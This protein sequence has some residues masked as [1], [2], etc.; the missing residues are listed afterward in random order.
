MP[1]LVRESVILGFKFCPVCSLCYFKLHLAFHTPGPQMFL[2]RAT[3]GFFEQTLHGWLETTFFMTG[4]D[5]FANLDFQKAPEM[6]R[7][8]CHIKNEHHIWTHH[9]QVPLRLLTG[10]SFLP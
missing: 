6:W 7:R 3:D 4:F 5:V 2:C 9:A 1:D 8:R 10:I